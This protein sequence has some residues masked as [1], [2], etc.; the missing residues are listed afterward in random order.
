MF[1]LIDNVFIVPYSQ[2][3]MNTSLTTLGNGMFSCGQNLGTVHFL[4][5]GGGGGGLVGFDG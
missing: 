1:V 5:G 4:W 2:Q 3:Y